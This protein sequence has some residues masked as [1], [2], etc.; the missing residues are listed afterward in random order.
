M[1][2]KKR[3]SS[4]N[5]LERIPYRTLE[6]WSADENGI[7]TLE[8]ENTGV[9]NRIFQKLFRKPKISYVHLEKSGSYLWKQMDG[10][11]TIAQ[12]SEKADEDLGHEENRVYGVAEYMRILES[13]HFI[14]FR[15]QKK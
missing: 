5:Y 15:N 8:K 12:L 9:C 4:E 3:V 11:L 13:Y 6:T 10:T 7:V 1:K 14:A 2:Q